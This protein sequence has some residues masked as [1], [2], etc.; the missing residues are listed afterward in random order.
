M[1]KEER[2]LKFPTQQTV[3]NSL[4]WYYFVVYFK[5]VNSKIISSGRV[6]ADWTICGH[7]GRPACLNFFNIRN[8]ANYF[9]VDVL[10]SEGGNWHSSK[11]SYEEGSS[12]TVIAKRLIKFQLRSR[13]YEGFK[14]NLCGTLLCCCNNVKIIFFL[15]SMTCNGISVLHGGWTRLGTSS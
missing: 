10:N 4:Q 6:G 2:D 9:Y 12:K 13:L 3:R 8:N 11:I 15:G 5:P 14:A 1:G 7:S